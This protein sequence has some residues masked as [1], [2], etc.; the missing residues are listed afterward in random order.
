LRI[1]ET[2]AAA[3]K[4]LELESEKG[5]TDYD[6]LTNKPT[7]NGVE[8]EGA[9]TSADLKL[10]NEVK[11]FVLIADASWLSG[12]EVEIEDEDNIATLTA[13]K[14][15]IG[16][17]EKVSLGLKLPVGDVPYNT[18]QSQAPFYEAGDEG[19]G[20]YENCSVV[21]F[22]YIGLFGYTFVDFKLSYSLT[23]GDK[24]A[25][26]LTPLFMGE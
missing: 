22:G 9:L 15:A 21:G 3:K 20:P 17:G 8:V 1:N 2:R 16:N 14:T 6:E 10:S 24:W 7:I 13:M 5:T 12:E 18:Y 4:I 25:I 26:T 11:E 23:E 19:Y